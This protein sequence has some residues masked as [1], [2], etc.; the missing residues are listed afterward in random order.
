[1]KAKLG[2]CD[3][4]S[5]LTTQATPRVLMKSVAVATEEIMETTSTKNSLNDTHADYDEFRTISMMS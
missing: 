3:S 2:G 5:N 1:M 4:S